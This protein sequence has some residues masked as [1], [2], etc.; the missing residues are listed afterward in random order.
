MTREKDDVVRK[1]ISTTRGSEKT[2][3]FEVKITS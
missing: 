3:L 2:L 1:K